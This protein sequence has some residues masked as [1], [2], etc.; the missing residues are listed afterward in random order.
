MNGVRSLAGAASALLLIAA[1]SSRTGTRGP[2]DDP[3]QCPPGCSQCDAIGKCHDCANPGLSACTGDRV[4]ACNADGT[5]GAIVKVCDTAA[6]E[7]CFGADCMSACD[8]AASTR[9][10]IGCDYWPTTTLTSELNPYFDFAVAV[11]NPLQVGD[12][13]QSAPATVTITRNGSTVA[14][15]VV[16][17][18][19]V[20]T[21][22]LPWVQELTFQPTCD[23]TGRCTQIAEESAQVVGGAY[24]LVSTLPVTVYQFSPL[25]FEKPTSATCVD[26]P[27]RTC[28]LSSDCR[29]GDQ[30]IPYMG[31][32][33]NLVCQS[34][35]NCHSY[36]NDASILLPTTALKSEYLAISRQT[37]S[38]EFSQGT[39]TPSSGF[40]AIVGTDDG[41]NVMVTSTAYTEPGAGGLKAMTP[42]SSASFLLNK[43]DV[44]Q[45]VSQRAISPCANLSVD[46]QADSLCDLGPQYD[47][48]GSH[49][50]SDKPVAVFGGHSCSF[51][52]YDKW[53]CDHLEEQLTPLETWGQRVVVA[54]TRPAIAGEPNVWRIVSGSDGNAIS[55]DPPS[56][57]APITLATGAY[58]EFAAQGGFMVTGSGRI[59]VGQYMVGESYLDQTSVTVGDPSLGLGVPVEQY[60]SNYDFIS[61][62]T[63]TENDLTLIAPMGDSIVLDGQPVTGRWTAIGASG[64][65]YQY[66]SLKPGAHHV[67][68]ASP[69]GITVSGV[70]NYTSYLYVGGQNLNEIPIQ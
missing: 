13:V 3:V 36:T 4:V 39:G 51:V 61:P 32:I 46:P 66:V 40:V 31:N 65:G 34:T 49:I 19:A 16:Q 9:S 27:Y 68:G 48:T 11:A 59:A 53:A 8:V 60:R 57:H 15:Q 10:Y 21:I 24:H 12:G 30:C 38:I 35:T 26:V 55:F 64:Y 23:G 25:Q 33:F 14:R 28:L 6:G 41:T 5:T 44:L 37:Y 43:G 70:A 22:K 52:P 7:R 62:A 17:P 18:G 1:C 58:V 69:F 45:L 56:V 67:S 50:V 42:G 63:Y 20:E 54:Q 2:A 47:L 29:P